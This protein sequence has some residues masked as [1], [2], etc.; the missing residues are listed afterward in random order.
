[1]LRKLFILSGK[2]G[3]QYPSNYLNFMDVAL[4]INLGNDDIYLMRLH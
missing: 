1:M 3:W 4:P 2:I